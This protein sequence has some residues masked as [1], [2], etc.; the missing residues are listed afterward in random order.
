MSTAE[1]ASAS[2]TATLTERFG[3]NGEPFE[4]CTGATI[5]YE[6]SKE[7]EAQLPVRIQS[8]SAPDIAYLPQPGLLRRIVAD[9]P[10]AILPVGED[11]AANVDE[12]YT[13]S[14]KEYG[15]V[16]GTLYATPLGANVK[17]FVWYS[18]AMFGIFGSFGNATFTGKPDS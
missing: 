4:E 13:E 17:S 12:Y 7:F 9:F 5:E 8:G 16:D 1:D 18:P 11:A 14:W 3:T 6:G 10:D 2:S 15:T